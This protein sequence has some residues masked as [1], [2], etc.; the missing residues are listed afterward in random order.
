M[1]I[2]SADDCRKTRRINFGND[3]LNQN[4]LSLMVDE[5][6]LRVQNIKREL[7]EIGRVLTE[8]K[9]IIGHGGFQDWMEAEFDFS[10]Q[11]ANNFMHVYQCCLGRPQLVED[12]KPSL[13]YIL[14]APKFQENIRELFFK[15]ASFFK[16]IGN[17][18]A[19]E[20]AIK[21][22]NGEYGP[23]HQKVKAL[24]KYLEDQDSCDGY[25]DQLEKSMRSLN[26][27]HDTVINE[28]EG[29]SWPLLNGHQKTKL[30]NTQYQEI[31]KLIQGMVE[32][33]ESILPVYEI[34]EDMKAG[35]K[36]QE[37]KNRLIRRSK[38]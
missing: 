37:S 1:T 11:T 19:K 32:A 12:F 27:L 7:Y 17:K 22:G 3:P 18:A 15:H 20:I 34:V 4:Q 5:V 9:K 23:D 21:Y 29:I 2:K 36:I 33:V 13:L 35:F 28:V 38:I 31:S 25:S 30:T 6:N 26:G 16:K 10:Y 8:A 14:T 24:I